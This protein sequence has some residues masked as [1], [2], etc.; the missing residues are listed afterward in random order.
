VK[1]YAG[2]QIAKIQATAFNTIGPG[3]FLYPD[4]LVEAVLYFNLNKVMIYR[5]LV[6]VQN[7]MKIQLLA[8]KDP[9]FG[10]PEPVTQTKKA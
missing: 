6:N 4:R 2:F 5:T 1:V 10:A 9:V 8:E 7:I 3:I